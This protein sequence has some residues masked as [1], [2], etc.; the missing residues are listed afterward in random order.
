MENFN[1]LPYQPDNECGYFIKPFWERGKYHDSPNIMHISRLRLP[2]ER[3]PEQY[4][5]RAPKNWECRLSPLL[6]FAAGNISKFTARTLFHFFLRGVKMS[7]T[8]G[9][10]RAFGY[11]VRNTL[12]CNCVCTIYKDSL[13][14]CQP[15]T[16]SWNCFSEQTLLTVGLNTK[17]R[18]RNPSAYNLH[19]RVLPSAVGVNAIIIPRWDAIREG[20]SIS[21]ERFAF[22]IICFNLAIL[23]RFTTIPGR[24]TEILPQCCKRA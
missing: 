1:G 12:T 20:R 24:Q 3:G 9:K 10:F 5:I 21:L 14:K 19:N 6:L 16:A 23:N 8:W 13:C 15:K 4:I 18:P 11:L 17:N 7:T 2:S 22:F